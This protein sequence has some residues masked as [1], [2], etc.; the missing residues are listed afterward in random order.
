MRPRFLQ[1]FAM[2]WAVDRILAACTA[3]HG[4]DVA[5]HTGTIPAG[6]FLL[7]NLAGGVHGGA[8]SS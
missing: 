4:T 2:G 1:I 7:A 3:A 8:F 6:A 5:T